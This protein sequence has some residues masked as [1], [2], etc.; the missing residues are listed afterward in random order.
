MREIKFRGK[1]IDNG[2]WVY[3]YLVK[4]Y[5]YE[6]EDPDS[7]PT[8]HYWIHQLSEDC[9]LIRFEVIPESVGE[10]IGRNPVVVPKITEFIRKEGVEWDAEIYSKDPKIAIL[11]NNTVKE[12]IKLFSEYIVLYL[13]NEE[14]DFTA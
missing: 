12:Q 7:D 9:N 5:T 4:T 8:Y 3:G 6:Y 1:R 2:E 14:G 13:E 10:Y 11:L